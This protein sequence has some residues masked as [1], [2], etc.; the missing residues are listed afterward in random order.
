MTVTKDERF[1]TGVILNLAAVF[2]W[3][4]FIIIYDEDNLGTYNYFVEKIAKNNMKIANSPD[5]RTMDMFY[6]RNDYP[7]WKSWFAKIISLKV[8]LFF[9]ILTP[10]FWFYIVESFY[11]AGLR[12]GDVLFLSDARMA[13]SIF[14]K[15]I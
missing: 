15:L 3:K 9:I 7:K 4:H 11:D 13:Y 14:G 10:P 2:G 12:R 6:T 5:L 1:N 8:R